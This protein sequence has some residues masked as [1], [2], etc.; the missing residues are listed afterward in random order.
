MQRSIAPAFYP[1]LESVRGLASLWVLV[2]HCYL[3]AAW[4]STSF[5]FEFFG[6][7]HKTVFLAVNPQPAVML[8]FV[9]SGFV[10]AGQAENSKVED[11]RAY[12][13]Y[14]VRRCFRLLP[15]LWVTTLV[16]AVV[17]IVA[18]HFNPGL[19]AELAGLND[20]FWGA[21]WLNRFEI[22]IVIW[23]LNI[24]FI[25]GILVPVMVLFANRASTTANAIVF[26][27]LV[28]L[29]FRND[30][31]L[32]VPYLALFQAGVL[33][34]YLPLIKPRPAIMIP[35]LILSV[36]ALIAVPEVIAG[37]ER[38]WNYAMLWWRGAEIIPCAAIV[39]LC[40]VLSQGTSLRVLAHPALRWLGRM[41]FAIYLLHYPIMQAVHY[42]IFVPWLDED[43]VGEVRM[44]E[45]LLLACIVAATS[46]G[47]ARILHRFVEEPMIKLGRNI[48]RGLSRPT[49]KAA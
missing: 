12:L 3:I 24:E 7:L 1:E 11:H 27:L 38:A 2:G 45:A 46:L 48:A 4:A 17:R 44:I 41:S 28:V 40:I 33:V 29:S 8:F 34:A 32:A 35:A 5:K 10:L 43:P 36:A 19:A 20:A 39:Y 9:L 18:A 16:A 25:I 30:L 23:T 37:R 42:C 22:N 31:P 14:I 49:P 13:A 26:A 47:L 6:A 15:L 21:L